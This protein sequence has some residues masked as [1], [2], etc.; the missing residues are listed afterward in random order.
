[1][2]INPLV[3]PLLTEVFKEMGT[4]YQLRYLIYRSAVSKDPG[5]SM[6]AAEDFIN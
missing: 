2:Y 1:M 3:D 6:N 4:M 5:E